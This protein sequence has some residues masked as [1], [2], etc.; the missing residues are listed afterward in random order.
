MI[1]EL[2]FENCMVWVVSATDLRKYDDPPALQDNA[3][4]AFRALAGRGAALKWALYSDWVHTKEFLAAVLAVAFSVAW[5]QIPY[6]GFGV[7]ARFSLTI[8]LGRLLR[9]ACF[10]TTVLPSPRPGCY[11]RRFP[12]PPD[13]AWEMLRVG[14]TTLRG[15]GGCNDLIFSGHG[16]FW[17]MA[18]CV[19]LS[20][21]PGRPWVLALVWAALAQTSVRDFLEHMHYSIDMLLAVVVTAAVWGW[22]RWVYPES[23]LLPRRPEGAP[24]DKANGFVLGVVAFGLFTAAFVIIVAKA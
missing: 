1:A 23:E 10:M 22:M 15:M 16:A 5:D 2:L 11:S 17:T 20:Y 3:E 9:V 18:P 4:I 21:Y 24:P 14:F 12:P 7:M 19:L 8:T 13:G 6:S